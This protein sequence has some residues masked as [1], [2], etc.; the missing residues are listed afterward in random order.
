MY[1]A[2]V[3]ACMI[4]APDQCI[5]FENSRFPLETR[6]ACESRA[7]QMANDIDQ[8][9][10]NLRAIKWRCYELREGNFT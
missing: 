4:A 2:V 9:L 3:I 10:T 6:K 7:M 1:Q 5:K 8:M